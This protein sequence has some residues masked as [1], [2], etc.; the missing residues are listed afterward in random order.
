M[1]EISIN[2][3]TVLSFLGL[4]ITLLLIGPLGWIVKGALK[5]LRQLE[6]DFRGHKEGLPEKYVPRREYEND[7]SEIKSMLHKIFDKLDEKQDK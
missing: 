4:V 6:S 2:A 7:V 5:D 3:Q 1:E